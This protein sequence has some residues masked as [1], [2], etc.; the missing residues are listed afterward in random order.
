MESQNIEPVT[1]R[2]CPLCQGTSFVPYRHL[3]RWDLCQCQGCSL[4]FLNPQPDAATLK[5]LYDAPEYFR[6]RVLAIPSKEAAHERTAGLASVI[7]K[8]EKVVGRKGRLLEIGSGYGFVLAAARERGWDAVGLELSGHA[9]EFS[10]RT[11]GLEVHDGSASQ[12]RDL[13][14]RNFDVVAM[15]SVIEHLVNPS[16]ILRNVHSALADDG[17]LWAVVP[18][19]SSLDRRWHGSEWTGWD[20][21]F[22]LWHF[23]PRTIKRLCRLSG[24][25]TVRTEN[26]FFNP[27]THI[28]VGRQV[29]SIRADVRSW[30]LDG[31]RQMNSRPCDRQQARNMVPSVVRRIFKTVF[32]ERDMHVWAFKNGKQQ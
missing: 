14:L 2:N 22:H 17:V 13:G 1:V 20:P 3:G 25:S 6:S 10:R 16:Q 4:V 18:N 12:I 24:F 27:L 23:S 15:L 19:L 9:V 11:F 7:E 28:R 5:R 31:K 8:L 26:T 29:G 30:A 32:S 21:P